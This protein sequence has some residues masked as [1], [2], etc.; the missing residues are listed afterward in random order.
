MFFCLTSP[1]KPQKGEFQKRKHK[2]PNFIIQTNLKTP[3]PKETL[4]HLLS[5][6]AARKQQKD[7]KKRTKTIDGLLL[8]LLLFQSGGHDNGLMRFLKR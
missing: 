5:T 7:T 8:L 4:K 1:T 2:N 3:K 6:S